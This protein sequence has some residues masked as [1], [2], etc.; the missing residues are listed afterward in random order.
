MIGDALTDVEAA[1]VVGAEPILVLTGRGKKQ[2]A[3]APA[4]VIVVRDLEAAVSK[5]I[6]NAGVVS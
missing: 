3:R 6:E 5:V 2:A 4:H 1:R